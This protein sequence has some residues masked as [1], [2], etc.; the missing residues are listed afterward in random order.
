MTCAAWDAAERAYWTPEEVE[1]R[2]TYWRPRLAGLTRL[3]PRPTPLSAA[4]GKLRRRICHFPEELAAAVRVMAKQ[5][6]ATLFSTL[7]TGFQLTLARWT[8]QTDIVVGT[9]MANRTKNAVKETMGYF[10]GVIPLRG[11]VDDERPF[12]DSVRIVHEETMDSFAN[13]LPFAE[14]ARA[15]GD[16]AKPGYNPIFDVRF[17]LQNHPVPDVEL[18]GISMKLRMRSTGTA[19]FDLACEITEE[20]DDRLEVVW[21]SRPSLFSD[22]DVD[23]LHQMFAEVLSNA[24]PPSERIAALV[25]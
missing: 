10:A 7:L 13:A 5:A 4:A 16:P 21:L 12:P 1:K 23:K 19:R 3:W 17:A 20:D 8:G 15:L 6:N 11:Q 22:S 2:M 18:M 14:L 24:C 25:N 9:P